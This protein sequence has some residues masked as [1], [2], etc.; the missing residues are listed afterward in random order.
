MDYS[1]LLRSDISEE[2]ILDKIA[3]RD[4]HH[5]IPITDQISTEGF[6]HLENQ[7][8]KIDYLPNDLSNKTVLEIGPKHGFYSIE[9]MNRNAESV[10]AIDIEPERA[11]V[12]DILNRIFDINVELVVGDVMDCEFSDTF[13]VVICFG[14]L[15]YIEDQLEFLDKVT[16]LTD[17]TLCI[18]HPIT[19]SLFD[20]SL[21]YYPDRDSTFRI[22]RR[23][24]DSYARYHAPIPSKRWIE[25]EISHRGFEIV[26]WDTH[27]GVILQNKFPNANAIPVPHRF[28]PCRY[29]AKTERVAS[30]NS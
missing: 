11:E 19:P 15:H 21:R 7:M 12:Y 18:E 27:V 30:D 26:D 10:T 22:Y 24:I 4:W 29:I 20:R 23:L 14:V 17:E 2:E 3:G 13:D 25:E 9:A 1:H 28:L 16:C 6:V 5:T 8:L